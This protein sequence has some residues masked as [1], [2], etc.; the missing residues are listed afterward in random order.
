MEID[1]ADLA[2]QELLRGALFFCAL[3]PMRVFGPIGCIHAKPLAKP[4]TVATPDA[5]P[6]QDINWPNYSAKRSKALSTA[7]DYYK[8]KAVVNVFPLECFGGLYPDPTQTFSVMVFCNDA[9]G[10]TQKVEI[11]FGATADPRF[12]GPCAV[13]EL[14]AITAST[15]SVHA[16]DNCSGDEVFARATILY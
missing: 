7:T 15:I 10:T 3:C 12:Q 1:L 9:L 2:S 5:D 13:T 11:I 4:M 16:R 14:D 6:E 8:D